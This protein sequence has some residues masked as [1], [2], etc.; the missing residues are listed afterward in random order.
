MLLVDCH[1]LEEVGAVVLQ[2]LDLLPALVEGDHDPSE[3]SLVGLGAIGHHGDGCP[4]EVGVL[5]QKEHLPLGHF[6]QVNLG[7]DVLALQ[8]RV[9]WPRDEALHV[10]HL[11]Q[12]RA[13]LLAGVDT[14]RRISERWQHTRL[15]RRRIRL[16]DSALRTG[17]GLGSCLVWSGQ[18]SAAAQSGRAHEGM[19]TSAGRC[20]TS[21]SGR[22]LACT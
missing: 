12:E 6:W 11:V 17:E 1:L 8:T 20:I 21:L 14:V 16:G 2:A 19:L 15:G 7:E 22:R 4:L 5:E 10:L 13:R 18:A 9:Q 3:L